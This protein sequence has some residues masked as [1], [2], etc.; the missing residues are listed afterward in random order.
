MAVIA[1]AGPVPH[2]D[3]DRGIQELR[4]LGLDPQWRDD[5]FEKDGFTAGKLERRRAEWVGAWQDHQIRAIFAARGG[6]G[7]A[8][9]LPIDPIHPPAE[10]LA[11]FS[12]Y[13]DLTFLHAALQKQRLVTFYGPMVSLELARGENQ[14]GG[15]DG[16]LL[17]RL[18]FEGS[19]G[20]VIAPEGTD[21]LRSG[22][23]EGRLAG[24][25]LSL[26]SALW[27]TAEAPDLEDTV[28]LLE[29]EKEAPY[30]VARYLEQLKRGGAFRGVRAVILGEFPESTPEPVDS[31]P[32]NAIAQRFFADFPGP[33]LWGFPAGHAT[34]P[35][36]TLPLGTWVKVDGATASLELLEPAV[37]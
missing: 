20:G 8:E 21:V 14:S 26:L 18:L 17:R 24:G 25:C 34:R 11:V 12:G 16:S 29:D 28:L 33:V 32:V 22:V 35:N 37:R 2:P 6:A 5:L 9:L 36:L 3:L 13:S 19:P 31:P 30:K 23:A 1:P 7:A 27:G 15:Y 10:G 4:R